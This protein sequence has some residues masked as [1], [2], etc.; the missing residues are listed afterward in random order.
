MLRRKQ[1]LEV[2]LGSGVQDVYRG[3]KAAVHAAG[4]GDQTDPFPD[5]PLEPPF[6]KDFDPDLDDR[7]PVSRFSGG[8]AYSGPGAAR[9]E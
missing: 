2:D 7:S 8:F 1:F 6:L 9:E 5:K 4:V 3:A